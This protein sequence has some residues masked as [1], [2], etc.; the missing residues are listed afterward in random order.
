LVAPSPEQTSFKL[1]PSFTRQQ[2]LETVVEALRERFSAAN[3]IVPDNIRYSIGFTK[4]KGCVGECWPP[5]SSSDQHFEL[6]VSP[7]TRN[8]LEVVT[9]GAHE[10]AHAVAPGCG[11]RG[12]F[13]QCALAIGLQSPMQ[14]TPPGPKFIA[15]T[16]ELFKRIGPYPA[17]YLT[18]TPKQTT[19]MLKCECAPCGYV[20]RVSNKWL[21]SSGPPICPNCKIQMSQRVDE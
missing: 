4:R 20:A 17:G 10:L 3:Y 14:V 7:E 12:A 2:W 16:D 6:F 11:H 19:R 15:F 8:G 13:K 18:D 5:S 1:T 9:T 21:V